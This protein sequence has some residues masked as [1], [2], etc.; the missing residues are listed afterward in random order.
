MLLLDGL[1][2]EADDETRDECRNR[3]TKNR[4]KQ[5]LSGTHG[6]GNLRRRIRSFALSEGRNRGQHWQRIQVILDFIH[7]YYFFQV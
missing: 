7:D 3:Q 5:G 6:G 4:V 2:G 1:L